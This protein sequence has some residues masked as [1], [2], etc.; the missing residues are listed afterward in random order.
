M[1]AVFK[2]V[3]RKMLENLSDYYD[4]KFIYFYSADGMKN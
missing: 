4:S 1:R 2:H 3:Y